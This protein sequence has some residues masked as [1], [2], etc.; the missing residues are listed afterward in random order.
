MR[1]FHWWGCVLSLTLLPLWANAQTNEK[2][3]VEFMRLPKPAAIYAYDG[4]QF[5]QRLTPGGYFPNVMH[6]DKADGG[7]A[8]EG[9]RNVTMVIAAGLVTPDPVQRA[10]LLEQ[11]IT[12]TEWA[13]T[14]AGADGS[15]PKERGGSKAKS[16]AIHPKGMFLESVA[17]SV[18]VLESFGVDPAY[19]ARVAALKERLVFSVRWMAGSADLVNF[20][21]QAK[22]TNQLLFNTLAIHQTGVVT[23]DAALLQKAHS[24]MERLLERQT[25]DGTIP[26]NGGF[27]TGYQSVSLQLLAQYALSLPASP[28]RDRVMAALRLGTTR[29][30]QS[31]DP[32]T[33]KMNAGA[34]TRTMACGDAVPG[35]GPKGK[36]ID[37]FP[38]RLY[39]LSY[40]LSDPSLDAL[41]DK[42]MEN[43]QSFDHIEQCDGGKHAVENTKTPKVRK[44]KAGK[45]KKDAS[46]F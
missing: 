2:S 29:L 3:I 5:A 6:G 19:Q 23:G 22:N 14:Q 4:A 21:E 27:D 33:G 13:F 25:E 17:R 11:G 7:V 34:N 10:A 8:I 31:I 26:E 16:N 1:R 46:W 43:G 37:V 32:A 18:W 15:F 45:V 12:A 44:N 9:Q 20:M 24:S 30:V 39:L 41:G 42:V 28:W 40:V 35:P 38:L 36:D